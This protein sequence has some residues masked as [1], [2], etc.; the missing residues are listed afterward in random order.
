MALKVAS[1]MVELDWKKSASQFSPDFRTRMTEKPS[2]IVPSSACRG[3]GVDKT[4][5]TTPSNCSSRFDFPSE[6]LISSDEIKK[7]FTS[8]RPLRM[9]SSGLTWTVPPN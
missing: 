2:G 6:A 4:P 5:I 8:I 7:R 9:T 3:M 1:A